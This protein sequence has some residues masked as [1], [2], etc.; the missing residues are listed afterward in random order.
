M[1]FTPVESIAGLDSF[2]SE[3]FVGSKDI[4]KSKNSDENR[5]FLLQIKHPERNIWYRLYLAEKDTTHEWYTTYKSNGELFYVE[6]FD[7]KPE[8]KYLPEIKSTFEGAMKL[9]NC[10]LDFQKGFHLP[11]LDILAENTEVKRLA[12]DIGMIKNSNWYDVILNVRAYILK[13][14]E[15]DYW[16]SHFKG[17]PIW[18]QTEEIG[19]GF[20]RNDFLFELY[21]EQNVGFEFGDMGSVYVFENDKDSAITWQ[22]S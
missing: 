18:V 10:K 14:T 6:R 22:C 11:H 20:A 7:S 4:S 2:T 21:S 9:K 16:I 3:I 8:L 17:Y 12:E 5:T 15:D 13:E 1:V 19:D